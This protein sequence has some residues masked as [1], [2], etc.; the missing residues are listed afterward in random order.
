MMIPYRLTDLIC[1]IYMCMYLFNV[2]SLCKLSILNELKNSISISNTI[3]KHF[4]MYTYM[5]TLY[6]T[7]NIE[8]FNKITEML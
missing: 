8:Y 3:D 1:A 2:I 7:V 5:R 4:I 6:P